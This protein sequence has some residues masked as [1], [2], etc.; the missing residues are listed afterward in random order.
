MS[1]TSPTSSPNSVFSPL[2]HR[3]RKVS[4]NL[5]DGS[6]SHSLGDIDSKRKLSLSSRNQFHVRPVTES[7]LIWGNRRHTP[8]LQ[9]LFLFALHIRGCFFDRRPGLEP[10]LVVN[11]MTV[12]FASKSTP[13]HLTQDPQHRTIREPV[14]DHSNATLYE[15]ATVQKHSWEWKY[16]TITSE[17]RATAC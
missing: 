9:R 1:E 13:R 17:Q 8:W 14:E 11:V 15:V 3:I 12:T 10:V 16:L 7:T 6:G 5:C 4:G 2:W